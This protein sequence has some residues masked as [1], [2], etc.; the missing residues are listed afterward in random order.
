L[1]GENLSKKNKPKIVYLKNN[2][3]TKAKCRICHTPI[4]R[5]VMLPIKST[6]K[7]YAYYPA[8]FRPVE[9]QRKIL[10]NGVVIDR[11]IHAECAHIS[12]GELRRAKAEGVSVNE[13][14]GNVQVVR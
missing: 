14:L 13:L 2:R 4:K 12:F 8:P 6:K 5:G 1:E 11:F 3:G 7:D 9:L 10:N